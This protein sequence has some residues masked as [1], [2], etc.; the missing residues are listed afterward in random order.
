MN[1]FTKFVVIFVALMVIIGQSGSLAARGDEQ[2]KARQVDF[3]LKYFVSAA[4][5]R[6]DNH[7]I[8]KRG[9]LLKSKSHM[10][11]KHM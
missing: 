11:K 6:C 2:D 8:C 4:I 10:F 7:I 1:Y 5:Q 9:R 3:I